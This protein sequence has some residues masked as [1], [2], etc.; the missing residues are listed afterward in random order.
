MVIFSIFSIMFLI[1]RL[2]FRNQIFIFF[3]D[4]IGTISHELSHFIVG[5]F[6]AAQPVNFSIFPKSENGRLTLGS[7]GFLNIRFFNA[8]PVGMSPFLL[9]IPIYFI[10]YYVI[11]HN[12]FIIEK[13]I[14]AYVFISLLFSFFPSKQDFYVSF[15][16]FFGIIFY[17]TIISIVLIYYIYPEIFFE[18]MNKIKEVKYV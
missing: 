14:L 5:L 12:L 15:S 13:I 11:N 16:N 18:Y 8:I 17:S 2:I 9:L 6:M 3:F 10:I 7:V 1:S 4:L